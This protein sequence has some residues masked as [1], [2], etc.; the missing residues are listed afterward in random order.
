MKKFRSIALLVLAITVLLLSLA[1]CEIFGGNENPPEDNHVHSFS[2]ATCTAPMICECGTTD[3]KAL[4][5][6]LVHDGTYTPPTCTED[7]SH[8][9]MHCE[10][11]DFTVDPKTGAN[12]FTENPASK[13]KYVKKKFPDSYYTDA[14]NDIIK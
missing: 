9:G 11:C 8:G 4:G 14:I 13:N 6:L 2:D 3:G 7:G 1:S 5:H 12:Y 10:R